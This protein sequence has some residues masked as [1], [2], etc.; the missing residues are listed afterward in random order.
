MSSRFCC[1]DL[2]VTG[3]KS[4][5]ATG[6]RRYSVVDGEMAGANRQAKYNT[7]EGKADSV[8]GRNLA[9]HLTAKMS[10][11]IVKDPTLK[12]NCR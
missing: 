2:N 3:T 4:P 1:P 9:D 12:K 7:S 11:P 5:S 10:K 8:S 6:N